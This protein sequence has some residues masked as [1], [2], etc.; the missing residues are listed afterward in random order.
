MTNN[1]VRTTTYFDPQILD[2]LKTAAIDSDKSFYEVL[3]EKL[4]KGLGMHFATKSQVV[5]KKINFEEV[6]GTFDLGCRDKI[7]TRA[8][9]YDE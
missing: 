6:F 4:A 9:A 1:L 3:N 8:D 5:H 7:F 2:Q